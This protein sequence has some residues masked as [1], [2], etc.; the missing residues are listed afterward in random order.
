[1]LDRVERAGA[2]LARL[3]GVFGAEPTRPSS[4]NPLH[5]PEPSSFSGVD[6]HHLRVMDHACPVMVGA[7]CNRRLLP[8]AAAQTT[9]N[10]QGASPQASSPLSALAALI[11]ERSAIPFR[12]YSVRD[13]WSLTSR[14]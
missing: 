8:P 9:D 2:D 13:G 7:P 5:R 6:S 3:V 12:M 4:V 14:Q 10:I 11:H 1:M